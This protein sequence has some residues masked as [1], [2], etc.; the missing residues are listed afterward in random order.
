MQP[1]PHL[2]TARRVSTKRRTAWVLFSSAIVLATPANA[3]ETSPKEPGITI[4]VSVD[5]AGTQGDDASETWGSAQIS[6]DGRFVVFDSYATSLVPND[7]NDSTDIFVRDRLTGETTR[8]SVDSTGKQANDYSL[9]AAI[10]FE[11]RYVAFD[12][13]ASNLVAADTNQQEDVFVHDCLT[14]ETTR[15]SVDSL[16]N[17]GN[18]FSAGSSISGNGQYV[19]FVSAA[20]NL[21]SG[22]TN[23]STDIFVHDRLTGETT[24]VSVDSAG[25]QGNGDSTL[26]SI[27]A[28]GRFVAFESRASNL[29]PADTNNSSDV[30]V[31]DRLTGRCANSYGRLEAML[32]SGL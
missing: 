6:A 23:N 2:R 32:G 15:M 25:N 14:G 20:T 5:S 26:P 24:R 17:Q 13:F 9:G 21:V 22:D 4:R 28:D 11:G 3:Q 29:I 19:A 8:V 30:F 27:S 7:T 1:K 18:N 16:G 12:S 31:H 10:S